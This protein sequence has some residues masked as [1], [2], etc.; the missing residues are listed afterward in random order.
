LRAGNALYSL[1]VS[2]AYLIDKSPML[3]RSLKYQRTWKGLMIMAHLNEWLK[4]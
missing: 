1:D 4:L 2:I 3:P